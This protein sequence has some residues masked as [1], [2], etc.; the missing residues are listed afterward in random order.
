MS[1]TKDGVL[2]PRF[3]RELY[4]AEQAK[5]SRICPGV[6]QEVLRDERRLDP[7]WGPYVS[8][9]TGFAKDQDTRHQAASG[10]ALSGFLM[11]L[12][13]T[14]YID[15]V[16][17]VKADPENPL[18]NVTTVSTTSQ[19]ILAAAGSR[20]APSSP[21]DILAKL[22]G[23]GRRFAFVGKPCDV[24]ALHAL[25]RQDADIARM[26]P[27]LVS[28]F[29]AGVP[30]LHGGRE[31]LRQL[32]IDPT[33]VLQFQHR[34]A[35]WPG[36]ATATLKNGTQHSMSYARSWG[37]ILSKR[38]QH[39]CKICADGSGVFADVV[40]ADAWETDAK[41]YPSFHDRPGQSLVLCR[42]ETGRDLVKAAQVSGHLELSPYQLSKLASVQPG[43]TR[44]RRV[45]LARLAALW[46]MGR[47]IPR[48][49][50]MG[51]WAMARRASLFDTIRNFGGMIRRAS[52]RAVEEDG[53]C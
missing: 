21:L 47:P 45:L 8:V 5:L 7:I 10:G 27:V 46:L 28:F 32:N 30:S 53:P 18:A 1:I 31:V 38:V 40:F 50:G 34:A 11:S 19:D 42:T 25:R 15:G 39:R 51:L 14:H 16:I 41:G 24:S 9:E 3:S 37:A 12:I 29:C 33:D 20:Y 52:R 43:Q 23:D 49:R 35:G 36:R 6:G 13:D 44:R 48:Y 4:P 17:H 22:R 26:V 2:R